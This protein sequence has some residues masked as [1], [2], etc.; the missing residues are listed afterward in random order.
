[1]TTTNPI[2]SSAR[3][4][5][6]CGVLFGPLPA[7]VHGQAGRT[8]RGTVT[9]E[10]D[11]KPVADAVLKVIDPPSGRLTYSSASGRFELQVPG[12]E[13]R[14]LVTRIGYAPDTVRVGP[15]GRQL[16]VR[17]RQSAFALDP[18][19]VSAEPTYSAASSRSIREF[20]IQLRPRESA[21]ELLRLAPGL[22]IAQ[23]AGRR[24][25]RADLPAGVR[26]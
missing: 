1:M 22:V 2:P 26:R 13:A 6:V 16:D 3:A 9:T 15:D 14:L 23:H 11:R 21:Q 19:T 17:L 10:A 8:I 25:G 4:V 7:L 20:D 24:K 18:I 12:G 5:L